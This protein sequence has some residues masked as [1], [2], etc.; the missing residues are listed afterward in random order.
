VLRR[1]LSKL[2]AW[3]QIY[4]LRVKKVGDDQKYAKVPAGSSSSQQPTAYHDCWI[5][6]QT[7][8][9]EDDVPTPIG[10]QPDTLLNGGIL[11]AEEV[12]EKVSCLLAAPTPRRPLRSP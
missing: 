4:F 9:V 7:I 1:N 2:A 8:Q 5:W 11:R 10:Q 12:L 6:E 3:E